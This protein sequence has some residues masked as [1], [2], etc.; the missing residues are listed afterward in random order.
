MLPT[1]LPPANIS[2]VEPV[3]DPIP[4]LGEHTKPILAELGYDP[5]QIE[6]LSADGVI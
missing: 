6:R 1:L 5:A 3:I 4:A 2:G